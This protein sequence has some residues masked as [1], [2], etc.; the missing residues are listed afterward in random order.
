MPKINLQFKIDFKKLINP[1]KKFLIKTPWFIA[2]RSF[3]LFWVVFVVIILIDGCIFYKY[4]W[5]VNVQ[6]IEVQ[7]NQ[8]SIDNDVYNKFLENYSARKKIFSRG[9]L[10]FHNIFFR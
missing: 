3:I 6:K 7:V 9:S 2:K 5:K 8:V 10:E 1:V 4:L